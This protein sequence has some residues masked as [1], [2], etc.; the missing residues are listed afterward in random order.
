MLN[1]RRI[2]QVLI[3]LALSTSCGSPHSPREDAIPCI[4]EPFS[5]VGIV[6]TVT[7]TERLGLSEQMFIVTDP[8]W[9][10]SVPRGYLAA[11]QDGFFISGLGLGSLPVGVCHRNWTGEIVWTYEDST[12]SGGYP[13]MLGDCCVR[14]D[15]LMVSASLQKIMVLDVQSG[16]GP[17]WL[18]LYGNIGGRLDSE[19][20]VFIECA[21]S[22]DV[23]DEF[24]AICWGHMTVRK[25]GVAA[26]VYN[27]QGEELFSLS[28][29]S[30]MEGLLGECLITCSD[31]SIFLAN[32]STD[33]VLELSGEGELVRTLTAGYT[34][35]DS[36]I[37]Q[38]VRGGSSVVISPVIS[39]IQYLER[40]ELYV[41]YGP[42]AFSSD[43]SEVWRINLG[44]GEASVLAVS[45]NAIGLSVWDGRIVL[46]LRADDINS[47]T[48]HWS[49]PENRILLGRFEQLNE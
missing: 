37:K 34:A 35:K 8:K 46:S 4:L 15:S 21:K 24:L 25:L 43:S 33:L 38:S 10:I 26:S 11:N 7:V 48:M 49:D 19:S 12:F 39:D 5:T 42:G 1:R 14:G 41:L 45:G 44:T 31:S 20:S 9:E 18:T 32:V 40:D 27:W 13:S 17:N 29:Q 28:P 22:L 2:T 36:L 3:F 23:S 6:D 47:Q 16:S 30:G